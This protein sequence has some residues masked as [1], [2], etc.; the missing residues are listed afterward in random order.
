MGYQLSGLLQRRRWIPFRLSPLPPSVSATQLFIISDE[1]T[2]FFTQSLPGCEVK[3]D[4]R[5]ARAEAW[6]SN[7]FLML[8]AWLLLSLP[9]YASQYQR[10][11]SNCWGRERLSLREQEFTIANS[12]ASNWESSVDFL[13]QEDWEEGLRQEGLHQEDLWLTGWKRPHYPDSEEFAA[14][15][16]DPAQLPADQIEHFLQRWSRIRIGWRCDIPF[17]KIWPGQSILV[18]QECHWKIK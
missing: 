4:Q 5:V 1:T 3:I 6:S 8:I 11:E 15:S 10:H 13:H 2:A 12:K 16:A 17:R 18:A 9:G 7:L 14:E